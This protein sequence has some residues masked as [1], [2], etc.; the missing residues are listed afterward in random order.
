MSL[1][2]TVIEETHRGERSYGI[3]SRLLKDRIIFLGHPIDDTVANIV[4]AQLL[5]LESE[6]PEKEINIYINSPGGSYTA[7]MAIY[8]TMQFVGCDISTICVGQAASI[9]TIL[10][11]GGTSGKRLALPHAR[12]HLHQYHGVVTGQAADI[13]IAAREVMH[14]KSQ[15]MDILAGHT[16]RT[17]EQLLEDTDRDFYLRP[18][19]AVEYGLIDRI[20]TRKS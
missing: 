11:T 7:G 15:V 12:M 10:L 14:I 1:P 8:D 19:D 9:A 6:D 2:L 16:G 18:E 3:F 13:D 5:F 17:P 20:V 4:I